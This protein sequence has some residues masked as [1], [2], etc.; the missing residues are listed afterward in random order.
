MATESLERIINET[1]FIPMPARNWCVI[2]FPISSKLQFLFDSYGYKTLAELHGKKYGEL[3]IN[4]YISPYLLKEL[5]GTLRVL[6]SIDGFRTLEF[7]VSIAKQKRVKT[8]KSQEGFV[9]NQKTDNLHSSNL[10]ESSSALYVQEVELTKKAKEIF[11]ETQVN[12]PEDILEIPELVINNSNLE[13]STKLES[14]DIF[15]LMEFHGTIE[16]SNSSHENNT[17][18]EF[19]ESQNSFTDEIISIPAEYRG[20]SISTLS[21][22]VRLS[23]ILRVLKVQTLGDLEQK[24][25]YEIKKAKNCGQTTVNELQR[26]IKKFKGNIDK[27]PEDH[28]LINKENIKINVPEQLETILVTSLNLSVRLTTVLNKLNIITIRDFKNYTLCEIQSTKNCGH[29]TIEELRHL[30][31][32]FEN[33]IWVKQIIEENLT[34][35]L[36][37][38]EKEKIR[39]DSS[40][41]DISISCLAL[42]VRLTN[43][44]RKLNVDTL[45]DLEKFSIQNI[46]QS[47]NIG[48]KTVEELRTFLNRIGQASNLETLVGTIIE[49]LPTELDLNDLISF[50]NRFL[51]GLPEREREIF[52]YRLGGTSDE[53]IFTLDE[54]GEKFAL[55]RER[56]RQ[57]EGNIIRKLNSR[58][59]G[60]SERALEKIKL[61]SEMAICPVSVRFLIYLTGNNYEIFIYPPNFYLHLLKKLS[62]EIFIFAG[63]RTTVQSTKNVTELSKKIKSFL[64]EE[65]HFLTLAE[66]FEQLNFYLVSNSFTI[67]DFFEAIRDDDFVIENGDAP[68]V[69]LIATNKNKLTMT[70][71]AWRVLKTSNRP[72][73]PEE[74]IEEAKKIFGTE[75]EFHSA[76][77]LANLPHYDSRFYLLGKRTIGL[78]QHFNL[79]EER[80]NKVVEDFFR[81]LLERQRP[82]STTEVINTNL[83]EWTKQTTSSEMAEILR[84][85]TRFKDLGRFLFSLSEWEIEERE[86]VKELIVRVL[87]ETDNA[88]T[89]NEIATRIHQYRSVSTT[90]FS[91]VLREHKDVQSFPFGYYGLK[92]KGNYREFF[93]TNK[94]FLKRLIKHTSPIP[95][96]DLCQR[97]DIDVN[98]ELA[99]KMWNTLKTMTDISFA[100]TYRSRQTIIKF[101]YLPRISKQE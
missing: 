7:Q 28:V 17:T 99:S 54:V 3:F 51:N 39:I 2:D 62:P 72:L 92:S 27:N 100:P 18:E 8:N 30:I 5:F 25:L 87:K 89:A 58:L 78:R 70:E 48:K 90:G 12:E 22:S 59:T 77:S 10:S 82:V 33:E 45:G 95:F 26:L 66:V 61:A 57:I 76:R 60:I 52:L 11:H 86:P 55:T 21:M 16:S 31:D 35:L 93:A 42:S 97:L 56:V 14:E 74:I 53:K 29:K 75:T 34:F 44:L 9:N 15:D 46:K 98:E 96:N 20:V 85:D 6:T 43:V 91:T 50:I 4:T 23:N 13:H 37:Q 40:V 64:D 80:W 47:K 68:D 38:N 84:H 41:K 101:S 67:N 65:T 24:T 81:L 79:P 49:N 63:N 69:M 32:N 88:L 19:T 94:N 36:A 73:L 83:F 1:V 71:I